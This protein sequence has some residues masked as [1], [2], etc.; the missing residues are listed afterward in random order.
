MCATVWS[1]PTYLSI[2]ELQADPKL[3]RLLPREVAYRFHALPV[4]E[5]GGR[6]TVVMANPEDGEALSAIA[7]V[8][9]REPC[10]VQGDAQTIDASLARVWSQVL[11]TSLTLLVCRAEGPAGDRLRA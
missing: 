7:G 6:I 10:V 9:G 4:A 1:K 11:R 2:D 8:L 3:A 5:Q